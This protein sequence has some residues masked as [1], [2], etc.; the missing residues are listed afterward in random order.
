MN[1]QKLVQVR[2]VVQVI[3]RPDGEAKGEVEAE[4]FQRVSLGSYGMVD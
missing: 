2:E 4:D 1:H 3:A